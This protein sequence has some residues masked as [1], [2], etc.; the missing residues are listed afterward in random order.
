M[1][2]YFTLPELRALPQLGEADRYPT[3]RCE[4]AAAWAVG[5]IEREVG[6]SFILR[7]V[8]D[9]LHDGG[10]LELVLEQ[11]F[12]QNTA[13]LAV[14][15]NGTAVTATLRVRSGVLR[16]YG[17]ASIPFAFAYGFANVS[18]TYEYGY[19]STVPGDVKE[20]ALQ[21]T[22]AHLLETD[23]D[24]WSADRLAELTNEMGGTAKTA[25]VDRD[26]PTGY[27]SIDAVIVAWRDKIDVFG[28]A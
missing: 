28:F 19:S 8:T 23:S 15:E 6:T 12:A 20:A 4:A 16:K 3:D 26:H 9:E 11:P 10:A 13:A 5:V 22:R 25:T 1:P 14:T 27:P 21:L 17:A 2:E 18:V 7:T 24:G